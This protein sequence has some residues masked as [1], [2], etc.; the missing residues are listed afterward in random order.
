MSQAL[1][2]AAEAVLIL[3][4]PLERWSF[5][6]TNVWR[7]S[8]MFDLQRDIEACLTKGLFRDH[9]GFTRTTPGCIV[10]SSLID[11]TIEDASRRP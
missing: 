3:G 1:F 7:T 9:T 11:L 6:P 4:R 2:E 8:E 5:Y 10:E